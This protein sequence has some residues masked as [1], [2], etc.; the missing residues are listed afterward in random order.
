KISFFKAIRWRNPNARWWDLAGLGIV[1]LFAIQGLGH[2][3]PIPKEVP[4]DKFFENARDAYLTSIFAISFGPFMEEVL[5][6][7]FLYPVLARRIGMVASI[8]ITGITFGLIHG[9]QLS[10]AWGPVLMISVVGIVLTTVRAI[11]KSVAASLIV[12]IAYNFTLTALTFVGTGGF[13]HLDRL[14]Q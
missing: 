9:A 14:T 1:L 2:F 5:F 12:H 13:R 7:G 11:K 3:L 10:F 6:R 4:F 8:L